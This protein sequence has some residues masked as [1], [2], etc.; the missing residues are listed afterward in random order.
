M[1]VGRPLRTQTNCRVRGRRTSLAQRCARDFARLARVE[2]RQPLTK[3]EDALVFAVI[4]GPIFVVTLL[5]IALVV[6]LGTR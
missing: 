1:T 4:A 3:R 2:P 5:I 6:V